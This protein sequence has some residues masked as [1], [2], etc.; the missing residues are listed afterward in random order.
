MNS[1]VRGP[2]GNPYSQ[3]LPPQHTHVDPRYP[4]GGYAT[5]SAD[6]HGRTGRSV[7]FQ[8]VEVGEKSNK[9]RRG[10]LPKQTTDILRAWLHDHLDH[11]YPNE[12]Q[13]Q[14]L[15]RETGLTDKQV[16]NWFINARRRNVPRLLTQAEQ[17]Q[18]FKASR[19]SSSNSP[20]ESRS[21]PRRK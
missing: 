18:E 21:P 7:E 9:K 5:Q 3:P 13:K 1:S 15:I 16:S 12:E 11:A 6:P 14:Q 2:S 8:N 19:A 17:E 10:N 4:Y 20:P